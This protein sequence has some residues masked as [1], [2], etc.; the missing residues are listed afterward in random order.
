MQPLLITLPH[1]LAVRIAGS[2]PAGPGSTPGGGTQTFLIFLV[3]SLF[4]CRLNSQRSVFLIN[5]DF[6]QR[7]DLITFLHFWSKIGTQFVVFKTFIHFIFKNV[8]LLFMYNH[9]IMVVWMKS[10]CHLCWS[11]SIDH[12]CNEETHAVR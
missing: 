3:E 1:G 11:P 12:I 9:R 2:H 8:I 5:L 6:F 10:L 4:G 7:H